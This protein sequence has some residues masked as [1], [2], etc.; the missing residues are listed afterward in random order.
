MAAT[1]TRKGL[2]ATA[3][4][5]NIDNVDILSDIDMRTGSLV[6]ET[7][8]L[9]GAGGAAGAYPGSL[10]TFNATNDDSINRAGGS[11]RLVT[12]RAQAGATSAGSVTFSSD[13]G[14]D[15]DGTPVSKIVAILGTN[16][17]S[18]HLMPASINGSNDLQLDITPAN[19]AGDADI[20]VLLM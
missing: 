8:W 17:R 13:T 5:V 20:T 6:D 11:L 18:A 4:G 1:D 15:G 19:A 16:L 14:T 2:K 9:D 7:R 3:D 12:I 10:T